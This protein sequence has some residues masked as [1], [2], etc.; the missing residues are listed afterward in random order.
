ML[1]AAPDA[2]HEKNFCGQ[3]AH[4]AIHHSVH[5]RQCLFGCSIAYESSLAFSLLQNGISVYVTVSCDEDV[6]KVGED[7]AEEVVNR[8]RDNE[9]YKVCCVA[10][11]FIAIFDE[12]WFLATRPMVIVPK[13]F[14]E[15]STRKNCRCIFKKHYRDE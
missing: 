6:G 14:A 4:F 10:I 7:E 1:F 15:F 12:M 2:I 3:S 13:F 9:W 5:R 11:A 8:P